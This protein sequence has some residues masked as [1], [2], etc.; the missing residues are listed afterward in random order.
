MQHLKNNTMPGADLF[1]LLLENTDDSILVV[2]RNLHALYFNENAAHFYQHFCDITL[3]TDAE[4]PLFIPGFNIQQLKK[5]Y[6]DAFTGEVIT[7]DIVLKSRERKNY[8]K[9]T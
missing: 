5:M 4:F 1:S 6:A 7:A 3:E 2:D 9:F 8:F